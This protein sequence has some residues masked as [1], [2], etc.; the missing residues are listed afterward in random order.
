VTYKNTTIQVELSPDT[1]YKTETIIVDSPPTQII[2]P[3]DNER[4]PEALI[5]L[6][7]LGVL[8]GMFA[9]Y[10]ARY[11]FLKKTQARLDA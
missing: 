3:L 1:V 6:I 11:L 9:I 2:Q 5:V 10:C 7:A 8:V 4:G